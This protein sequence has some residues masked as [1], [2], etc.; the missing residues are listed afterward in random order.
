MKA[1]IKI[2]F[3]CFIVVLSAKVQAVYDYKS[4]LIRETPY[5]KLDP[6]DQVHK[7]D[8]DMNSCF[9]M[10]NNLKE[11]IVV[12]QPII[13]EAEIAKLFHENYPLKQTQKAFLKTC[14]GKCRTILTNGYGFR[15]TFEIKNK[16]LDVET[17][18]NVPK[19]IADYFTLMSSDGVKVKAYRCV[20]D[21]RLPQT[22]SFSC[23]RITVELYFNTHDEKG[24]PLI[25]KNTR[26]IRLQS[27][28]VGANFGSYNFSWWLPF[29]YK[30]QRPSPLVKVLGGNHFRTFI[31]DHPKVY[32]GLVTENVTEEEIPAFANGPAQAQTAKIITKTQETPVKKNL[33]EEEKRATLFQ[34]IIGVFTQTFDLLP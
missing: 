33:N 14:L 6:A 25:K 30:I 28:E 21:K 32:N 1:K 13:A 26:A 29:K 9:N 12:I 15:L 2:F 17:S 31:A 23:Q 20:S 7:Y 16:F 11:V 5:D 19:N 22:L 27:A 10:T 3:F 34:T 24:R 18:V 8:L 4:E